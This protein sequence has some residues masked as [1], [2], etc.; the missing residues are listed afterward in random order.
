MIRFATNAD[1]P[2]LYALWQEAFGDSDEVI[3]HYFTRRHRNDSMLVHEEAGTIAGM[4]TMLPAQLQTHRGNLSCRYVYAVATLQS[5]RRRGIST[6]LL[7]AAHAWM[8]QHGIAA[9]V[10]A[11]ADRDLINFYQKRGYKTAFYYDT[12]SLPAG[13]I[14]PPPEGGAARN[15]SPADYLQVR[16]AAFSASGLYV[17]WNQNAIEFVVNSERAVGNWVLILTTSIGR[18]VAV[19]QAWGEGTVRVAELALDGMNAPDAIALIHRHIQANAYQLRL[20]ENVWPGANRI[21]GGMIYP[22]QPLP[23]AE[24]SAPYI[25]LIKD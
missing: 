15:V 9:S 20:P 12:E 19:C 14:P 18:A 16:N 11:P 2:G 7:D 17:R 1:H 23:P 6:G 22:L 13:D 24:G 8:R 3:R 4:L 5:F 25:G 10:L 21:P